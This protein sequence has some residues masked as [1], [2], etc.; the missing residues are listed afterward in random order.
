MNPTFPLPHPPTCHYW[1][2]YKPCTY[3]GVQPWNKNGHA[4]RPYY[5][6][7]NGHKSKF[8]TFDDAQGINPRN[9]PCEGCG[10]ISRRTKKNHPEE[11]WFFS[12]SVGGCTW[13][14]SDERGAGGVGSENWHGSQFG[15]SQGVV[16][17]DNGFR[18]TTADTRIVRLGAGG[19]GGGEGYSYLEA[20]NTSVG[21]FATDFPA[22]PPAVYGG[23]A[24]YRGGPGYGGRPR[25][26][27][28]PSYFESGRD[29]IE[30]QRCCVMM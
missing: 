7:A 30:R 11:G 4:F 12:C 5:H 21:N 25:L 28:E 20:P 19:G 23:R 24:G 15:G 8:S 6:C 2:C 18:E 22:A 1:Q 27:Y 26:D 14:Q 10:Y 17:F 13:T 29:R 16:T 3:Q 9:P